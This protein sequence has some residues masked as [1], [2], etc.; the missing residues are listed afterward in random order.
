MSIL[1]LKI[2][3]L[4]VALLVA[5]GMVLIN[6]LWLP[7]FGFYPF[8]II[9]GILLALSGLALIIFAI[10]ALRGAK[11]TPNPFKPENATKL[12]TQGIY[13]R[14]R[15]PIY[16]GLLLLLV[17]LSAYLINPLTYFGP[18]FFVL[19]MNR[20][21]ICPEEQVLEK[22]FGSAFT[23]YCRRVGRWI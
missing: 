14:S 18:L 4:I 20:F 2:P 10:A 5:T 11:T 7:G 9:A 12:V 8:N 3:P 23:D 22:L 21:Q 19:Y 16:L 17:A 15:N 6:I 13:A 1:A